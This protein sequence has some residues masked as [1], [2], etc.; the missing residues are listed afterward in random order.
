MTLQLFNKAS[1]LEPGAVILQMVLWS[2]F[3]L[4]GPG[5]DSV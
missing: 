5:K 3:I 1:F 4:E 2:T